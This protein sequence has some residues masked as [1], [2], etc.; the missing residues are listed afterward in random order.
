[1]EQSRYIEAVDAYGNMVFRIAC[2]YC[3]CTADAEDIVQNV[4]LKLYQAKTEFQDEEHMKRWLIRVTAN[5]A[6]NLVG[7]FWKKHMVSLEETGT[8]QSFDF[9]YPESSDLYDAVME[10]PEKYRIVMYLYYYEDYSVKEIAEILHLRET[11]VQTQLMRGRNK[12][13][14]TLK[15]AWQDE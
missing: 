1:M 3:K 7:S 6:K 5:E 11:T 2:N 9:P 8:E 13:K 10:L 12:L 4:F 14:I 15:E